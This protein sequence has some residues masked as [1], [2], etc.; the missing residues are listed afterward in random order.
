MMHRTEFTDL[1]VAQ[2]RDE[3]ATEDFL[4]AFAAEVGVETETIT[5]GT[6]GDAVTAAMPWV[7]PTNRPGIPKLAQKFLPDEVHLDWWQSWDPAHGNG[8]TGLVRV[9]LHG[10]PSASI[11]GD[12]Q[13]LGNDAG[14]AYEVATETKTSLR[15]PMNK[16]VE[17]SID[18]DLVGWILQVQARVLRRRHGQESD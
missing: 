14:V 8:A 18:K 11:T 2:I 6:D 3:F 12:S 10:S 7:F 17:P 15:W 1:G 16:T 13:L 9:E 4:A 5:I